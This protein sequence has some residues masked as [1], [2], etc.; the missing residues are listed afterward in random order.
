VR[1][2]DRDR[3]GPLLAAL[4]ALLL[5]PALAAALPAAEYRIAENGTAYSA[6]VELVG[7]EVYTV[8]APGMLGEQV[9]L[10]VSGLRLVAE[11]GTEVAYEDYGRA[12]IVFPKGNYTLEFS[13]AIP[14]MSLQLLLDEPYRVTVT[15]PPGFGVTNPL[16]GGYAP[17]ANLTAL[18]DGGTL[19]AWES[20]RQVGVRFYDPAREELLWFFGT[21]WA[22]IAVVLLFPFV[23]D[24]ASRRGGG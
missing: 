11:N 18:P 15:V 1:A 2:P 16:L 14:E 10:E 7:A 21:V 4:C 22:V 9:P 19:L 13:G 6:T 24:R 3:R 8:N 17:G 20:T 5:I 23:A 12:G